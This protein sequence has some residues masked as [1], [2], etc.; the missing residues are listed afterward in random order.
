MGEK[1]FGTILAL[2][3]ALFYPHPLD[4]FE[5]DYKKASYDTFDDQ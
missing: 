3:S 1:D 2:P 5:I 4:F